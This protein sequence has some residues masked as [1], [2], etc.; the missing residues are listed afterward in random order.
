[1]R[2]T[3]LRNQVTAGS[4]AQAPMA[5]EIRSHRQ[6]HQRQRPVSIAKPTFSPSP[7]FRPSGG[8]LLGA[9]RLKLPHDLVLALAIA[10]WRAHDGGMPSFANFELCR[11]AAGGAEAR[12]PQYFVG[13]DLGQSRDP[14]AIAAVRR[15]DYPAAADEEPVLMA[16][17]GEAAE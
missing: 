8:G 3:A 1:M 16:P 13:V 9:D 15:V 4:G 7:R 14:T 6:G 2:Q 5:T 10:A 17:A 11:L 12:A